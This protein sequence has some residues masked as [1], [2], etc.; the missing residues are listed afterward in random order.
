MEAGIEDGEDGSIPPQT[1]PHSHQD[2]HPTQ[3][4]WVCFSHAARCVMRHCPWHLITH[5]H[6]SESVQLNKDEKHYLATYVLANSAAFGTQPVL[7]SKSTHVRVSPS[8]KDAV[9]ARLFAPVFSARP[10]PL[11]H[12]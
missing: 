7:M 4:S 2:V 10:V 8:S 11:A 3:Q 1:A 6:A 9:N 12:P 5:T